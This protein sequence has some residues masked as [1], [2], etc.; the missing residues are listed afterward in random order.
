SPP[1]STSCAART[2]SL[3]THPPETEPASSPLWQT[4]S[5]EPTGRGAD[6]RVATTVAIATR[7]PRA[8]QRSMSGRSSFMPQM[9]PRHQHHRV[10][11]EHADRERLRQ[12]FGTVAERYDR[13]RPTYPAGVYDDLAALAAV[14]PGGRILE[15]GP[16]TGKATVELARRG[17]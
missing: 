16:G 9:Y 4:A 5:F 17:Y 8:R 13:A 7:S 2:T 1:S 14:P 3:S 6:R 11:T 12:T 10:R 15:I